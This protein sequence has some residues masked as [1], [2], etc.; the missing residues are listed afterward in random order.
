MQT[1][2][3]R[4]VFEYASCNIETCGLYGNFAVRFAGVTAPSACTPP[5]RPACS[6]RTGC[7]LDLLAA[8]ELLDYTSPRLSCLSSCIVRGPSLDTRTAPHNV[9]LRRP[10]SRDR[11]AQRRRGPEPADRLDLGDRLLADRRHPRR[12]VLEQRS[13]A[14]RGQRAGAGGRESCL[15][16]RGPGTGRLLVKGAMR[17][18]AHSSTR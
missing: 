15:Q 12:R 16:S 10:P 14:V 3:H 5:L 4:I 17:V 2:S 18:D 6:T 11:R 1:I 7:S 9:L 13:P 8:Q